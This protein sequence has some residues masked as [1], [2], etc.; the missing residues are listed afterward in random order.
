[1]FVVRAL[2][3][4]YLRPACFDDVLRV[5]T[6]LSHLGGARIVMDQAILR[7]DTVLFTASVTLV[8]VGSTGPMR[9]PGDLRAALG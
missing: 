6:G 2:S 3:A 4:E 9:I 7:A 5:Q 8:C 1:V